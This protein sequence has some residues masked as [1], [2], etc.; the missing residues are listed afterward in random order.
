[1]CSSG[2]IP[3]P[4]LSIFIWLLQLLTTVH[5]CWWTHFPAKL[6]GSNIT[7]LKLHLLSP[8][9]CKFLQSEWRPATRINDS[10]ASL[11]PKR[12]SNHLDPGCFFGPPKHSTSRVA[13]VR[14]Q[15]QQ[16]CALG[17]RVL[18]YLYKTT[19]QPLQN[20]ENTQV[21]FNHLFTCG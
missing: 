18:F 11:P 4:N 6:T 8:A 20:S 15:R 9:V 3:V 17:F 12:S 10:R 16:N 21:L 14:N 1:M 7:N 19:C 5:K 13:Q 2:P